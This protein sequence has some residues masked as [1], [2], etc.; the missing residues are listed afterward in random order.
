MTITAILSRFF[1]AAMSSFPKNNEFLL[2]SQKDSRTY[3][4]SCLLVS[5]EGNEEKKPRLMK[6]T[7]E[8]EMLLEGVGGGNFQQAL[9]AEY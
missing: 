9:P 5:A 8:N 6:V 4:V 2:S 1:R 3:T 7:Q